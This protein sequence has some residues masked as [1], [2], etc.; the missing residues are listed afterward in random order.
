MSGAS[1]CCTALTLPSPPSLVLGKKKK[2]PSLFSDCWELL[3]LQLNGNDNNK[4]ASE[5][6]PK[7]KQRQDVLQPAG[8][9]DLC[10]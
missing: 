1:R 6:A 4:T 5:M 8:G 10:L 9:P 2:R 7:G 3:L